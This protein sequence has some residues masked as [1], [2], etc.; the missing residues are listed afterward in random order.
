MLT[1]IK[2]TKIHKMELTELQC[3]SSL[4]EISAAELAVFHIYT[5][6]HQF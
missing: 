2:W 6:A 3:N 5:H 1:L 4:K